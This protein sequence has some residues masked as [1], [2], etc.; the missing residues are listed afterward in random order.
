MKDDSIH[1]KIPL[2]VGHRCA[3]LWG[4]LS[5][6]AA[7]N[8]RSYPWRD[9]ARS[10]YDVMIAE[11]LL[12]RTTAASA[13][14]AYS[15]FLVH[16]PNIDQLARAT[17]DTLVAMISPLGLQVQ[18]ARSLQRLAEYLITQCHGEV[19]RSLEE[20]LKIPCLGEYA[21]RAI[22]SFGCGIPVAVV[23]ANVG[24]VF[25]RLFS[26]S[27]AG[28]FDFHITQTLAD[29]SLPKGC[30][31]EFNFAMLDLGATVCRYDSPRCDKC[32]LK[33]I[34]DCYRLSLQRPQ[35]TDQLNTLRRIR[36]Q[37]KLA[38]TT[39]AREAG[40]SKMTIINIEAGRTIPTQRTIQALANALGIEI[41]KLSSL[42]K[43]PGEKLA[44]HHEALTGD[45]A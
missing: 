42:M 24:R 45:W 34:C 32:P 35:K 20:L 21:S 29:N 19:P 13:V 27:V 9:R 28:R 5:G 23:D 12:K 4:H 37:R 39:L 30:H 6:W 11:V 1:G 44:R 8:F 10:P 3:L 40:V 38:L 25:S 36:L 2:E 33:A 15:Q 7:A 41:T 17:S 26:R 16:F 22:L 31:R 18:R 14:R 43:K